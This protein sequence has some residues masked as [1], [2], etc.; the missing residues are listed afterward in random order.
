MYIYI[1]ASGEGRWINRRILCPCARNRPGFR[2]TGGESAGEDGDKRRRHRRG[3]G[4]QCDFADAD[5]DWVWAPLECALRCVCV[6]VCVS[7]V[8]RCV[9]LYLCLYF[10]F[11]YLCFCVS[12]YRVAKTHRM[13]YIAGH[14]PQKSH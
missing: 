13:P 14:F 9:C 7:M 2:D 5:D 3:Y 12:G 6:C 8:L 11:P 10:L 1:Q 4:S